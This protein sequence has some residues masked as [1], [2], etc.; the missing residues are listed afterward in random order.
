MNRIKKWIGFGLLLT[1]LVVSDLIGQVDNRQERIKALSKKP[2]ISVSNLTNANGVDNSTVITL[3]KSTQPELQPA[4]ALI[5]GLDGRMPYSTDIALTI[6]ERYAKASNNDSLWTNLANK[7]L[8]ILPDVSSF[9][10]AQGKETNKT[11]WDDD[12][13]GRTDEDPTNDLNGDG[14]ISMMRVWDS[15]GNYRTSTKDNRLLIPINIDKNQKGEFKLY[16]EG[17]DDDG[18][19]KI[20]EDGNGGTAFNR[21]F[22]FEYR[23]FKPGSGIEPIS[24]V[25]TQALADFFIKHPNIQAVFV[26]GTQNNLSKA[27]E[28]NAGASNAT[29]VTAPKEKDAKIYGTLSE[30]YLQA[31]TYAKGH[32]DSVSTGGDVLSWLYYHMGRWSL[33]SPAWWIPSDT[34]LKS[35]L[36][37]CEENEK[38]QME[39]LKWREKQGLPT[40]TA[41]QEVN[42]PDFPNQK[43]EVGGWQS[44]LTWV[45]PVNTIDTVVNRHMLFLT[46]LMR[47]LPTLSIKNQKVTPKG[48]DLFE[49]SLEIKNEGFLPTCPQI[50]ENFTFVPLVSYDWELPA[51]TTIIAGNKHKTIPILPPQATHRLTW[52]ILGKGSITFK[53][54]ASNTGYI[55]QELELK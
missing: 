35:T 26:I 51:G 44:D 7:T 27:W 31:V 43:V 15:T 29:V 30:Q 9:A 4:V 22:P 34:T 1:G 13:D 45:L 55:K 36:K 6:A 40:V 41:W 10:L 53:I 28:F 25:E 12:R 2:K 39:W 18:D 8:Y 33:G 16:L 14:I 5:A 24:E 3:S 37:N 50:A 21:N 20:N 48:S 38:S 42:H 46:G 49:V 52:T 23:W 54:G 17:K 11:P 19:T 47:K 32:K